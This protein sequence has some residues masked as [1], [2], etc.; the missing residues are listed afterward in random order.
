MTTPPNRNRPSWHTH[1]WL[2][3]LDEIIT[4]G[5]DWLC[6]QPLRSEADIP[7]V[8]AAKQIADEAANSPHQSVLPSSSTTPPR[9][10]QTFDHSWIVYFTQRA[11][12]RT[13]WTPWI[14]PTG[15]MLSFTDSSALSLKGAQS[16]RKTTMRSEI[17]AARS[18]TG[19]ATLQAK[20]AQ[21]GNLAHTLGVR[22]L[23][24]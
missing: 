4:F 5:Q 19:I 21:C 15:P 2:I 10:T 13:P 12:S 20:T 8:T 11:S 23:M 16:I 18:A 14:G 22:P 3:E 17:F 24:L 9:R 1:D 7:S 6:A